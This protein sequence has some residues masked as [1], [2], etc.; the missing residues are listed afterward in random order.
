MTWE[1]MNAVIKIRPRMRPW[2]AWL[3]MSSFP[4]VFGR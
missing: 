2:S 3:F 4:F 1:M